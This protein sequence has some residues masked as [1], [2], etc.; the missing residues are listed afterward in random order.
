MK[1]VVRV[2]LQ[3]T[4]GQTAAL[5][6]ALRVCN[7]AAGWVSQL[8]FEQ[9]VF[10]RRALQVM[11]SDEGKVRFGLSAQPIDLVQLTLMA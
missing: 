7:E 2:K 5:E 10:S 3:P 4:P 9:K 11:P 1:L 6:S 8:A